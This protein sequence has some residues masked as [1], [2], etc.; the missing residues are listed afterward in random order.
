M[1]GSFY[2]DAH[3]VS[4]A[5]RSRCDIVVDFVAMETKHIAMVL[6]ECVGVLGVYPTMVRPLPDDVAIR[7]VTEH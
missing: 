2:K 7:A 1:Q 6:C 3:H 5:M 4:R